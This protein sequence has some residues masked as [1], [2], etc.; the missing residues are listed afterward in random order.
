MRWICLAGAL[1]VLLAAGAGL[2][3]PR[4]PVGDTLVRST[5]IGGTG[6]IALVGAHLVNTDPLPPHCWNSSIVPDY[7]R[8]GVRAGMQDDFAAMRA[9]GLQTFRI[10]LYHEHGDPVNTNVVSSSGGHLSEPFRTNLINL[11]TDIRTA[12]FLQLTLAFNPWGPK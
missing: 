3:Q 5:Q 1:L 6:R 11:L 8:P 10:F 7:G 9:A 4:N 2:A 12:G